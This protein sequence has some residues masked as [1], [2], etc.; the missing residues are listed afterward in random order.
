MNRRSFLK[1]LLGLLGIAA[2]PALARVEPEASAIDHSQNFTI[3]FWA[4]APPPT[5]FVT[6]FAELSPEQKQQWAKNLWNHTTRESTLFRLFETEH[7][8][9][10]RWHQ[11]AITR[12]RNEVRMYL[13]G[14]PYA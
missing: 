4:K 12:N 7:S 2:A 6:L 1:N 11:Y 3:K 10:C 13:D 9:A 5:K 8:G 14:E